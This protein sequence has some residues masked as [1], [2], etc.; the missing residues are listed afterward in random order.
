MLRATAQAPMFVI[1]IAVVVVI[2]VMAKVVLT[3]ANVFADLGRRRL[4]MTDAHRRVR[5][6]CVVAG[7]DCVLGTSGENSML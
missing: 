7:H 6:R 1:A 4:F 5:L 3:L 2:I